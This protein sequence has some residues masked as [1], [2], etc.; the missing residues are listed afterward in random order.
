[1]NSP[2]NN[3]SVL[4]LAGGKSSRMSYPKPW[5]KTKSNT[6]F[7]E[8]IAST[9]KHFG[10]KDIV[11]V[12]NKDYAGEKW[13]SQKTEVEKF[14]RIIENDKVDKGRLYSIQ[15]GL[16]HVNEDSIIIHNVDNPFVEPDTLDQLIKNI[17]SD[18]VTIPTFKNQ[19]GHPVIINN[20]VKDEIINNHNKYNTLKDLFEKF[21]KKYVKVEDR[22]IL[23]NINT[24]LDFMIKIHDHV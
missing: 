4:I 8:Q 22:N 19:G 11:V 21:P 2:Y 5:L 1:M 10:I 20:Q 7:L 18:G 3:Y 16:E 17:E 13:N 12:L 14:A 15:L 23:T 6:T 9:F 24:P